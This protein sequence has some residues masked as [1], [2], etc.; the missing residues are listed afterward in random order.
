MAVNALEYYWWS[1]SAAVLFAILVS[2]FEVAGF[3]PPPPPPAPPPQ[4]AATGKTRRAAVLPY[5]L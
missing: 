2:E 4:R 3:A 1:V 5:Q